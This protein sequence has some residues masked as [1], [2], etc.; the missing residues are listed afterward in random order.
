MNKINKNLLLFIFCIFLFSCSFGPG[1]KVWNDLSKELE[2]AKDRKNTKLI[3]SSSQK[4]KEKIKSNKVITIS[5]PY[6]NKNWNQ[7]NLSNGNHVPNLSYQNKKNLIFKSKKLG[8]NSF[9]LYDV[10][11]QP[12]IENDIV[13]FYDPSGTIFSYSIDQERLIWKYNFYKK[14]YKN[15]PKEINLYISSNNLIVSDNLGF[16]YSLDKSSGNIEWAKSYGVPFKSNIKID[17]SNIFLVN[18][19]N[20]FYV[21]GKYKGEQRLDLETVPSFLKSNNKSN[22]SLDST[23]KNVFFITSAAEIYSL[24]YKNRNI[25]W[26]FNLTG[27]AF[28]KQ[29]D[30]FYSSPIIYSEDEIFLSTSISSFSMNSKN[31]ALNWEF[32][33]STE[34]SPVVLDKYVFLISKEGFLINLDRKKGKVV[35]S[36]NLFR[37]SKKLKHNKAGDITSILLISDQIFVTTTNGYFLFLNYQNGEIINYAKVSKGFFSKPAVINETI[38]II[39]NKMRVLQFN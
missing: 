32:P 19:D 5:K 18:Q 31:G 11:F 25:N 10:D 22:I 33:F 28:D 27:G 14:R 3:F 21:L 12:L 29:V 23:K 24:N 8:K 26:L 15:I 16:V 4:F 1:T 35:W 7:Q 34:I 17:E 6:K 20:K 36:Q 30:L 2:I 9:D 13:V 37:G 39:D 38:F